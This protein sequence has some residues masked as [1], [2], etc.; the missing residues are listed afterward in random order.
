MGRRDSNEGLS[1]D[2]FQDKTRF[3]Y[4]W[5]ICLALSSDSVPTKGSVAR[6]GLKTAELGCLREPYWEE[7]IL[8]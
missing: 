6:N 8:F 7:S 1:I 2:A 4:S 5:C 3:A